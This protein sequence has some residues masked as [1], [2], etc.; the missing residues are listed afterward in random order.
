MA[1]VAIAVREGEDSYNH[2]AVAIL[3]DTCCTVEHLPWEISKKSFFLLKMG[4]VIKAEIT[5]LN[6]V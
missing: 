2:H 1:E 5:E 6:L 3:E 4:G